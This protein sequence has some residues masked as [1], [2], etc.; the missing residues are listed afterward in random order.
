ME[1]TKESV[2]PK[3]FRFASVQNLT[4]NLRGSFTEKFNKRGERLR[5]PKRYPAIRIVFQHGYAETEDKE[6]AEAL[7]G[8]PMWG[9]DFYWHKSMKG[10][11]DHF[12]EELAARFEGKRKDISV[13]M[14]TAR[15]HRLVRGPAEPEKQK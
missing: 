13:K 4:V 14:K 11:V 7:Q 9:N 6:I 10:K 2:T 8:L 3:R 12:D 15:R 1:T 5:I